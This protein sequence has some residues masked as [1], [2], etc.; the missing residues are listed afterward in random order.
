M[1]QLDLL[2][3]DSVPTPVVQPRRMSRV[4]AAP[5]R[6][7]SEDRREHRD[8]AVTT[9]DLR[10]TGA[11]PFARIPTEACIESSRRPVESAGLSSVTRGAQ[12]IYDHLDEQLRSTKA[13]ADE[14]GFIVKGAA[15]HLAAL[16]EAGLAR[17]EGREWRRA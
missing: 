10:S 4:D 16:A 14:A 12:V 13:I 17:Q 6:A 8:S 5:G 7:L 15:R 9:S 1:S 11:L 3:S 2:N